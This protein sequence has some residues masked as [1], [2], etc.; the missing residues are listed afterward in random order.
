MVAGFLTNVPASV[1]MGLTDFIASN[2]LR[3][4]QVKETKR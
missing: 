3:N 1:G 2:T 4:T